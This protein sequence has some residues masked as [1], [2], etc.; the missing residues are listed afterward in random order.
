MAITDWACTHQPKKLHRRDPVG[1]GPELTRE[2]IISD[3]YAFKR[4]SI[5]WMKSLQL[6]YIEVYIRSKTELTTAVV[7]S[8][9]L[10]SPLGESKSGSPYRPRHRGPSVRYSQMQTVQMPNLLI[11]LFPCFLQR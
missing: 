4:C 11:F 5:L 3:G 9:V 7:V 6:V 10:T 1:Y 2:L 8:L